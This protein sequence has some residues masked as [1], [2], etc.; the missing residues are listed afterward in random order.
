VINT[1]T[2]LKENGFQH[3]ER[4]TDD[5]NDPHKEKTTGRGILDTLDRLAWK[6]YTQ[7]IDFIWIHF[8]G[9]GTSIRDT[10]HDERDGFDECF[11][12]S[13]YKQVGVIR[14]DTFKK[15]FRK[16]NARTRIFCLFDCCHSGTIGDLKY[17]YLNTDVTMNRLNPLI[18]N[19][20]APCKANIVLMSGC[21]DDQT[22][23]DAFNVQHLG[24]FTGAMT[25]CLLLEMKKYKTLDEINIF[26]LL[27]DVRKLLKDK[28]FSQYPQLTS[29]FVFDLNKTFFFKL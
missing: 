23:A 8:S 27:R 2:F 29:S 5:I 10:S 13:D 20:S 16:F 17:R 19:Y 26:H 4:Y 28:K 7:K 25:S 6:T 21:S 11:V 9:H 18:T 22:S 15:I 12:P 3:I 1:E 24:K 14:D